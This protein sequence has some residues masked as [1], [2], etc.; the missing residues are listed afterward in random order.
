MAKYK[1]TLQLSNG[2]SIDAG[3]FT[4][5]DLTQVEVNLPVAGWNNKTQ[6]YTN[7]G[8]TGD[9]AIISSPTAGS[10]EKAASA[11][12]MSADAS[13][14]IVNM[15]ASDTTLPANVREKWDCTAINITTNVRRVGVQDCLDNN[16]I[17][18]GMGKSIAG[19]L[20]L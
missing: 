6:T 3:Q 12:M 9:S 13:A 7:A 19:M 15:V 2:N 5:V 20:G 8:I 18:N 17:A 16:G 10:W 1:L 14:Q 4:C 11:G